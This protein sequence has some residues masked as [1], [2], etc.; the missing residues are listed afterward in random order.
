LPI[1]PSGPG[2]PERGREHDGGEADTGR[3]RF[4]PPIV[5]YPREQEITA[6]RD[7]YVAGRDI[8]QNII[9]RSLTPEGWDAAVPDE[10]ESPYKV[11][12]FEHGPE[13]LSGVGFFSGVRPHRKMY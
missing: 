12:P 8:I 6:G 4:L 5:E 11:R 2:T 1:L 9:S 10:H 7:V 3:D 13:S